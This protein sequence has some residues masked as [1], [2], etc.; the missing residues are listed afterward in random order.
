MLIARAQVTE[1]MVDALLKF[2]QCQYSCG[3]YAPASELLYSYRV[4]VC[5]YKW[6]PEGFALY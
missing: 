1:D 4:L 5:L 3:N 6:N 2:G